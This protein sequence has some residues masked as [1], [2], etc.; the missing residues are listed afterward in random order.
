MDF[1]L[2]WLL[3]GLPVA[4]AIGWLA[5]RFDMRHAYQPPTAMSTG[6]PIAESSGRSPIARGYPIRR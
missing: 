1:D 6:K 2:Q 4:F 3:L 5:S